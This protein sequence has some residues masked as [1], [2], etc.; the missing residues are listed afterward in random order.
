MHS[1]SNQS[2]SFGILAN[3]FPLFFV[4]GNFCHSSPP[5]FSSLFT[6]VLYTLPFARMEP[7]DKVL[8]P[9][10]S[11]PLC[12]F[13]SSACSLKDRGTMQAGYAHRASSPPA[14]PDAPEAMDRASMMVILCSA[15]LKDGCRVRKY[16]VVQ[17]MMPPPVLHQLYSFRSVNW[18]H[19]QSRYVSACLPLLL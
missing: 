3:V 10:L 18:T 1:V 9:H 7:T 5:V 17:P 2:R 8:Y 6:D 13:A 19:R 15:G 16:A 14:L 4:L 12:S 11:A